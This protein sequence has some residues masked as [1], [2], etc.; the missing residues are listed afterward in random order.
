MRHKGA[1]IAIQDTVDELIEDCDIHR[2]RIK[3]W[4][5]T[6]SSRRQDWF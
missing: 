3:E 4:A 1:I 2:E 5:R 6:E